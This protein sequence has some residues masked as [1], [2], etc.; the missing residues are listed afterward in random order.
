MVREMKKLE[1]AKQFEKALALVVRNQD[2]VNDPREVKELKAYCWQEW[3]KLT[4]DKG[5]DLARNLMANL[6]REN[7]GE[8]G[9]GKSSRAISSVA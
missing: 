8:E 3:I 9:C 1:E 4:G 2:L 5:E 7:P 6:L